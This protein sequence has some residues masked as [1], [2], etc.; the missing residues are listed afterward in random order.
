MTTTLTEPAR[1]VRPKSF[2]FEASLDWI[3]GR[4]CVVAAGEGREPLRVGPPPEFRGEPGLWTPEHLF[5]TAIDSCLMVTFA[6]MA[7][8]H[9]LQIL[10]YRSSID[11]LLEYSGGSFRFTEVVLKP[12]VRVDEGAIE[13]ARDLLSKAHDACLISNSLSTR[14]KVEPEILV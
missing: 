4:T 13:I 14:V 6:G 5:L 8:R 10:S 11:G 7:A 1:G 2:H 3:E 12:K 9:D